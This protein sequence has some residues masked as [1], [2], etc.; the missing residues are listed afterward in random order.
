MKKLFGFRPAEDH[1]ANIS[2]LREGSPP[3]LP[4]KGPQEELG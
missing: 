3:G 1:A 4:E 2:E